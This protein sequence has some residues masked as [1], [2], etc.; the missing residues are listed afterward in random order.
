MITII[1]GDDVVASRKYLLQQK[2]IHPNA[3][4]LEGNKVTLTELMQIIE[5]G[6]LFSEE[7]IIFIEKL[8]EAKTDTNVKQIIAYLLSQE[9]N[10][11]SFLW[12]EK[13][14]S[15]KQLSVFPQAK[16]VLC[17]LPQEIF[18]FL[19]AIKPLHGKQLVKQFHTVITQ[20]E[21][22]FIFYMLI[23]QFRLLISL[24]S[25]PI[26]DIDEVKRLSPWQMTKLTKQ[27]RLFPQDTLLK[28][29]KKL[30]EIDLAQK[31]GKNS[32][33]LTQAIDIFLLDI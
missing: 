33:S 32:L 21:V 10:S 20:S 8:F 28:Q 31:T 19:D 11:T 4:S 7:K 27:A 25:T 18:Q 29:Y 13:E 5:G 15:K 2:E 30:Y 26:A 1:H 22:E 14:L 24:R 17:K 23:R 16:V 12:E 3:V 9:K 6:G